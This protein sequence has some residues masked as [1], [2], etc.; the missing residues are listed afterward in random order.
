MKCPVNRY[1]LGN[2]YEFP[3]IIYGSVPG[4]T[5]LTV[6]MDVRPVKVSYR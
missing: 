2:T 5:K 3:V 4:N 6:S 1:M